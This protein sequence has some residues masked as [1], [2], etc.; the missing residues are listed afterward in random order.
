MI[1]PILTQ[2]HVTLEK[3]METDASKQ[4]T[5]VILS[6]YHIDKVAMQLHPVVYLVKTLTAT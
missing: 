2:F 5:A 6:Q 1:A 4:A 3:I